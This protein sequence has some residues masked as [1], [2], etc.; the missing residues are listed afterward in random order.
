MNVEVEANPS[1]NPREGQ[2][3][4]QTVD[5]VTAT[6]SI[7]QV[8]LSPTLNVDKANVEAAAA[9]Q[10]INVTVTSNIE[11]AAEC[12]EDWIE[13]ASNEDGSVL[14]IVVAQSPLFEAREGKVSLTPI[15]ASFEKY[16]KEITVKTG[17][18]RVLDYRNQRPDCRRQG[19]PERRCRRH[20]TFARCKQRMDNHLRAGLD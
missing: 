18:K 13:A 12:A 2:V 4:L 9:G 20:R 16:A 11:W 10:T 19:Q 6:L 5:G 3:T 15:D 7:T 17:S 14:T 8:G 1:E